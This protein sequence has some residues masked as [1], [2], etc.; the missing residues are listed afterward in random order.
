MVKSDN[1]D[2]VDNNI[3]VLMFEDHFT[4]YNIIMPN[5]IVAHNN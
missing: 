3:Y 2:I 5:E 4:K 1:N